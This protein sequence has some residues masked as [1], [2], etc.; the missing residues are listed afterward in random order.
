MNR[1]IKTIL[2]S[3]DQEAA[4]VLVA[5][6]AV[7]RAETEEITDVLRWLDRSLIRLCSKFAT[8]RPENPQT[9]QLPTELSTYP[10]FMFH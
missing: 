7:F 4:A 3:F 9:F 2:P 1:D 5:R 8:Y 10:Q 6:A